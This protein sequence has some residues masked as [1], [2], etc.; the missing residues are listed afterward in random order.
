MR[1]IVGA[2]EF[3]FAWCLVA[4]VVGLLVTYCFPPPRREEAAF[5]FGWDW[6][7]LPGAILGLFI[8]IQKFRASIQGPK[9]KMALA[10]PPPASSR[11]PTVFVA[12][13]N[14]SSAIGLLPCP[15]LY[16]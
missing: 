8:G 15:F 10:F 4:V 5:I 1:H 3:L 11:R 9:R 12:F 2:I 6:R 7:N 14:V 16:P 13:E